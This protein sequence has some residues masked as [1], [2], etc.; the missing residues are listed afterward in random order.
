MTDPA[1]TSEGAL[2]A[3]LRA[4]RQLLEREEKVSFRRYD[5]ETRRYEDVIVQGLTAGEYRRAALGRLTSIHH[6]IVAVVV[7]E[8]LIGFAWWL[9][10]A[11]STSSA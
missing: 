1:T 3:E 7:V 2:L 5:T 9:L 4:I 10:I 6:I 8:I 11:S